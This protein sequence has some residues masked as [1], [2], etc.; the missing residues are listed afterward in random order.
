MGLQTNSNIYIHFQFVYFYFNYTAHLLKFAPNIF[1]KIVLVFLYRCIFRTFHSAFYMPFVSGAAVMAFC[2]PRVI[3]KVTI[4]LIFEE[5]YHELEISVGGNS[6]IH[7]FC[8]VLC[9]LLYQVFLLF[10]LF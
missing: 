4:T 3:V 6:I 8:A 1:F 10:I 5:A 2:Q 9:S 7:L